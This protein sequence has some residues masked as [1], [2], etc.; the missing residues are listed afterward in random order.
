[1]SEFKQIAGKPRIS[2]VPPELI[3]AVARVRAQAMAEKYPDPEG[4]RNVP[5]Q[6]YVD[7]IGRHILACHYDPFAVDPESGLPHMA[8]IACNCAFLLEMEAAK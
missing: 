8:H 3:L 5:P 4:W 6:D 7:A 1:M 2:L